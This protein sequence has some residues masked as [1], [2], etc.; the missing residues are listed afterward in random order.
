MKILILTGSPGSYSIRRL[1]EEAEKRKHEV[2]IEDPR[3]LMT[4]I[5]SSANGYDR[6][7]K[8]SDKENDVKRVLAKNFDV[9]I[10]RFAGA[11]LFEF[12]CA[13][14]EHLNGNM[15]IPS[16]QWS[17]GLRIASN[18]F[19]S[20]QAF[21]QCQVKTMK[22]IFGHQ[23]HDVKWAVDQLGGFP[24]VCKTLAGS[25]GQGVFILNDALS[26]STTLGAFSKLNI[27]ILLQEYIDSGKPASDIRAYVIDG[28][29]KAAYKRFA[30]DEDF[31]GNY[32]ISKSGEKI[33]LTTEQKDLAV[34]AARAV[35]LEG[36]AAIDMIVSDK[37]KNTYVVEANGNGSLNGIEKV[38]GH[39][40]ALDI[41]KY[42][43]KIAKKPAKANSK[44]TLA[45]ADTVTKNQSFARQFPHLA[46]VL[47]TEFIK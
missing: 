8:K 32:S 41:L 20:V 46:S 17:F 30:L 40:L 18:K 19:L 36:C 22:A 2:V 28:E 35:G 15:K 31:R 37:T 24:V 43:E 29:V 39:N 16:T 7:F 27:N 14:L 38:T 21:S 1:K 11:N 23:V 12:G 33:E 6:V 47:K 3:Q 42:A 9:C 5:S 44:N 25:Q 45:S 4:F 10:P 26:A 34:R 13:L